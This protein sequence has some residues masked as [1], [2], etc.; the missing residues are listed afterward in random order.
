MALIG[1]SVRLIVKF[2]TFDGSPVDPTNVNL[3]ILDGDTYEEIESI[4]ITDE[5]KT[6]VGVYEY[7]Y[8]VPDGEST[9]LVYEYSG[10]YNDK[11]ILSRG[12]FRRV[13]ID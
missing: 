3:R 4:V 2:R 5:N 12:S 10:T 9:T 7:D 13:F 1:D 6:D 8:V 11:P